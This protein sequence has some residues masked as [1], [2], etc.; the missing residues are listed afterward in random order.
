[1]KEINNLTKGKT[2]IETYLKRQRR[3]RFKT[4]RGHVPKAN[5]LNEDDSWELLPDLPYRFS[6]AF[7][8]VGAK[9]IKDVLDTPIFKFTM[10]RS[11]GMKSIDN[12]I[13][14]IEINGHIIKLNEG[15]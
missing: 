12:L 4:L 3:R 7:E 10:A 8:M 11:F 14:Y 2:E 9:T 15:K 6:Y 13:D 1:M 5:F